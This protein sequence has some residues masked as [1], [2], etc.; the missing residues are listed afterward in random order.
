VTEP[1]APTSPPDASR[2]LRRVLWGTL[3]GGLVFAVA[4]LYADLSQLTAS[5]GRFRWSALALALALATG[6]YVVRF[7]RWQHYLGRLDIRVGTV[8]SALI[9]VAGFVMSVTPGKVGE[10]FKSLL[11]LEREGS[12]IAKTAPVVLAERLSDLIALVLLTALGSLAFPEGW[13]IAVGGAVLTG[14]LLA[15]VAFRPVAELA[16]A[17]LDRLPLLPRLGPKLREAYESLH[18]L[19]RPGTLLLSTALSTFAWALEGISLW[20]LLRGFP[21]SPPLDLG[22]SVFAYSAATI[23]GAVAMSPGGLGVTESGMA[24]F[25]LTL[26]GGSIERPVA[27]AAMLLCRLATLWWAVLL[28]GLALVAFRRLRRAEDTA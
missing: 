4:G 20:V 22:A 28:G 8:P 27:V 2:L 23:A 15:A 5:L 1:P 9:F 19:T 11:L 26:S 25:I 10:V 14:G 16:L 3:L 18:R 7:W 24:Y 17:T 21:G 13:P 6:N 12:P